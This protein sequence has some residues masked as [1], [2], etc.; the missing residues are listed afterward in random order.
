MFF[1]RTF[2]YMAEKKKNM[3]L[4]QITMDKLSM[5]SNMTA[6][7][8]VEL[9]NDVYSAK[10]PKH[11]DKITSK[12]IFFFVHHSEE[13]YREFS[14][15]KKSGKL[16][17]ISAPQPRLKL[18]QELIS[19][20][21]VEL[22]KPV[23]GA[24]G[25]IR[26]A[27]ITDGAKKHTNQHFVLNIDLKDFFDSFEWY[28]VRN[29]LVREFNINEKIANL[30]A[31]LCCYK[32]EVERLIDGEYKRVERNV[33][34]QGAPS[35]PV[36]TNI[37]CSTLDRRLSGLAKKY[38]ANYSRYADDITF[39]HS[40]NIFKEGSAFRKQLAEIIE[41]TPHLHTNNE[42]TRLQGRRYRQEVT[43][44]IVNEQTNVP[45]RYINQIRKW[46]YLWEHYGYQRADEYFTPFYLKD[47]GHIHKNC[48]GLDRVLEGKLNY[49]KMVKG[50]ESPT[51]LKL[52][53]RYLNLTGRKPNNMLDNST[54]VDYI[55][56]YDILQMLVDTM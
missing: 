29:S 27:N 20:I 40:K 45:K 15:K 25:F 50:A 37:L 6:E 17:T 13:M 19:E 10:Y 5:L 12:Q 33:L 2:L 38:G 22:Y 51:Y 14:I 3:V 24:C 23:D 52:R 31:S 39:S 46:L 56:V 32:H 9:L 8:F 36:L 42:K 21:L 34:P 41:A 7:A 54:N 28:Q 26:D 16:R 44:I 47:K 18:I 43:G 11:T 48:P 49:L 1:Q 4:P 55:S 30:I 35:S 53:Q